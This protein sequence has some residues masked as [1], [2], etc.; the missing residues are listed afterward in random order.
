MYESIENQ[1]K[2]ESIENQLREQT[3]ERRN[4][5]ERQQLTNIVNK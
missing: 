1:L 5:K 2:Y 4:L 3:I